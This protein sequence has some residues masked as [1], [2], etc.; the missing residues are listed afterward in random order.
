MCLH[1]LILY[2][3]NKKKEKK[4]NKENRCIQRVATPRFDN[5]SSA[6]IACVESD[7]FLENPSA[8]FFSSNIFQRK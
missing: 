8:Y 4:E 6:K 3:I 2:F 1:F 7:E 5:N